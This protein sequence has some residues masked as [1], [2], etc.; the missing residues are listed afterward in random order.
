MPLHVPS[1]PHGSHTTTFVIVS[2]P[3]TLPSA[4]F[5]DAGAHLEVGSLHGRVAYRLGQV[6]AYWM[7]T[8][9]A[10]QE[11]TKFFRPSSFR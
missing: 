2:S 7:M 3:S 10:F 11:I 6:G 9:E 1:V 4:S 8:P 5:G